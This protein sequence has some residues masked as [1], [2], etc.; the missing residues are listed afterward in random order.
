MSSTYS[1]E[2][3]YTG[4]E[5]KQRRLGERTTAGDLTANGSVGVAVGRCCV[6]CRNIMFICHRTFVVRAAGRP[7]T[8]WQ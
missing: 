1:R 3:P 2:T 8:W 4:M 7:S 6:W 5:G